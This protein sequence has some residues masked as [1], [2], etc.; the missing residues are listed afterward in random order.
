MEVTVSILVAV[1]N[2]SGTI[3]RFVASMAKQELPGLEWI[4]VIDGA[5]D[6]SAVV[7]LRELETVG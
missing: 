4:F 5:T 7:L 6:D 1:Y 3:A 2:A